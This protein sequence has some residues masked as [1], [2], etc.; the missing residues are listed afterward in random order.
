MSYMLCCAGSGNR[1]LFQNWK[2]V[3]VIVHLQR[4]NSKV[5][6]RNFSVNERDRAP[7]GMQSGALQGFFLIRSVKF[8]VLDILPFESYVYWIVHHC[9]S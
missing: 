6:S 9:N 7:S 4:S 2:M 5:Y 1:G 8:C 3:G